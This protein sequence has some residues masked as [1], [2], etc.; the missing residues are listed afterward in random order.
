MNCPYCG[1]RIKNKAVFCPY[2]GKRTNPTI[3]PSESNDTGKNDYGKRESDIF[4]DYDDVVNMSSSSGSSID[5]T[6]RRKTNKKRMHFFV[7]IAVFVI[8]LCI[9][10]FVGLKLLLQQGQGADE[11]ISHIP[12]TMRM[13]GKGFSDI[14]ITDEETAIKAAAQSAEEL[15]Y[16]NAMKDLVGYYSTTVDGET[17]YRLQQTYKGIPVYGRYVVVVAGESG[18]AVSLSTDVRDLPDQIDTTITVSDSQIKENVK[19]YAI[20]NWR[21][22]HDDIQISPVQ[23]ASKVIYD[24]TE[25]ET[26]CIGVLLYVENGEKTYEVVA[27]GKTGV[28]KSAVCNMLEQTSTGTDGINSFPVDFDGNNTYTLG[29]SDRNIEVFYFNGGT[30]GNI[31]EVE[32]L[33]RPVTS[34][35]DNVFGNTQEEVDINCQQGVDFYL[36]ILKIIDYYQDSFGKGIP[37]GNIKCG[38]DDHFD[39]GQNARGG[40]LTIDDSQRVASIYLGT[41]ISADSY[42]VI[43]H[44]YT[45]CIQFEID[46]AI[47]ETDPG[48]CEGLA[49]LFGVFFNAHCTG[50]LNWDIDLGITHRNAASPER[51]HYPKTVLEKNKSPEADDHAYATAVARI[52]Y[53]MYESGHFSLDD[54]QKLW[55]KTLIR[56][57]HSPSYGFLR[58]C[59]EQTVAAKYGIGSS[60]LTTVQ[61]I[62]YQIGI[63]SGTY[64]ECGNDPSISVYDRNGELY[65]DYD[66]EINGTKISGFL[67]RKK[68]E[69]HQS[70]TVNSTEAFPLHLE[71][72]TYTVSITDRADYRKLG[73]QKT[74]YLQL[75]VS[76]K[77]TNNV[78]ECMSGFGSDYVAV[79]GAQLTVLDAEE[80]V[81]KDY[82]ATASTNTDSKGIEIHDGQLNL[83]EHN[84]YRIV[85]A[86]RKGDTIFLDTFT[87]RISDAGNSTIV[88]KTSFVEA[89]IIKGKVIDSISGTPVPEVTVTYEDK[90]DSSNTATS[91]A[92]KD[93]KYTFENVPA[94]NYNLRF[95]HE[96]Y[97]DGK[98]ELKVGADPKVY[99]VE[100]VELEPEDDIDWYQYIKDVLGPQ[101]GFA[102]KEVKNGILTNDNNTSSEPGWNK[103]NG[104]ISADFIDMTEDGA[105]DL[106]LYR[107]GQVPEGSSYRA[108]LFAELY[109]EENGDVKKLGEIEISSNDLSYAVINGKSYASLR[110]G[111]IYVNEKPYMWVEL[112]GCAY[113]ANGSAFDA[114]FYG[115]DGSQFRLT[116]MN[117]KSHGGSSGIVYSLRTYTDESNYEEEIFYHQDV[118]QD[119]IYPGGNGK[120]GKEASDFAEAVR[121]GYE[122]LEL[123]DPVNCTYP[124]VSGHSN[125]SDEPIYPSYWDTDVVKK[126]LEINISGPVY[127]TNHIKDSVTDY[128][129]LMIHVEE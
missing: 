36:S 109:T 119:Y 111:T 21:E 112:F 10:G 17:F 18:Q 121:F 124:Y 19:E 87:L 50:T 70:H 30:S 67:G 45:H 58:D 95:T 69:F 79:P 9:A 63:T 94:G 91:T 16:E 126:T 122:L 85:L 80:N 11:E 53:L 15:G 78:V 62:F 71:N 42:T 1:R 13:L 47:D 77:N 117:G 66:L 37:F 35:G 26:A 98:A 90:D 114:S 129:D 40:T 49:D 73:E 60:E 88:R 128:S 57:P 55:Y 83:E 125:S 43:G 81:F 72:G 75:I 74:N 103:R 12:G 51:Y 28:V 44:E 33:R 52:G 97:K 107:Y 110:V 29:D 82:E 92:D 39:N 4:S 101:Y 5:R 102:D 113:Y 93:G 24:L 14:K 106:L 120:M 86:N 68:E 27:D 84:N 105:E 25:E 6:R 34:I 46:A 7:L 123:P 41:N 22:L 31:S 99:E 64:I 108:A 2:C 61:D 76:E 54:L 23:D 38:Y 96:Y 104:I 65:D 56:L 100:T 32:N 20:Y 89:S 3:H 115:W 8:L 127:E 116:W 48:I 118:A 59:M